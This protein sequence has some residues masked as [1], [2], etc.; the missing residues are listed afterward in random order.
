[1]RRSVDGQRVVYP[2][3]RLPLKV[4]RTNQRVSAYHHHLGTACEI[5]YIYSGQGRYFLDG[6]FHPLGAGHVFLIGD[7]AIHRIVSAAV[8]R[9]VVVFPLALI[10]RIPFGNE[11]SLAAL[12]SGRTPAGRRM[13]ALRA[14]HKTQVEVLL[15]RLRLEC[16]ETATGRDA[17]GLAYLT[18]LLVIIRR[19]LTAP[20]AAPRLA[21]ET[22]RLIGGTIPFI[23]QHVRERLT[24][25]LIAR[26]AGVNPAYFSAS[27]HKA[28][29]MTLTSYIHQR[30]LV[31]ARQLLETR[32]LKIC[33]VAME[34]GFRDVAHFNRI[35]KRYLRM[36]PGQYQKIHQAQTK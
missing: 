3:R 19:S 25:D 8:D 11:P 10:R 4:W 1:M 15:A 17:L 23:D 5:A 9:A 34:A 12:F 26:K 33:D 35:F 6:R 13:V 31:L 16:N 28:T 21:P 18:E 22:E 7:H 20:P 29:G 36:S 2:A 14:E 24:L 30:R 27:F 32:R